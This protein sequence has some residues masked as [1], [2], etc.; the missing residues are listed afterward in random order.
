MAGVT[1]KQ[2]AEQM[3]PTCMDLRWITVDSEGAKGWKGSKPRWSGSYWVGMQVFSMA[4]NPD[5]IILPPTFK[6]RKDRYGRPD[7]SRMVW[8]APIDRIKVADEMMERSWSTTRRHK[9]KA[10]GDGVDI[11]FDSYEEC[12]AEFGLKGYQVKKQ[13]SGIFPVLTIDA[14]AHLGALNIALD[15]TCFFKSSKMLTDCG[16]SNR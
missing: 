1:I 13:Y 12:A 15:K 5:S 8:E 9:V 4:V 14:V 2:I 6:V 3:Y 7:W 10:V 11:V 16:F